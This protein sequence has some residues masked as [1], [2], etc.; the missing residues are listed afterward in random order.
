MVG[1]W[2]KPISGLQMAPFLLCPHM[3]E[4][5]GVNSSF[6]DTQ[7]IMAMKPN[8]FL[9]VALKPPDLG[10]GRERDTFF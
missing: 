9:S 1:S 5:H 4:S 8:S 6:K 7:P 2:S 10:Q 3:T